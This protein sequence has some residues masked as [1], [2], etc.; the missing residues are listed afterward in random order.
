MIAGTAITKA[1]VRLPEL[2]YQQS[3]FLGHLWQ[4]PS[5]PGRFARVE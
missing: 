2:T 1:L 5:I 3:L 4:A